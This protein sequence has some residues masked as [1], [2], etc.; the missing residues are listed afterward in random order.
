MVSKPILKNSIEGPSLAGWGL[1]VLMLV[2]HWPGSLCSQVDPIPVGQFPALIDESSGI[3]CDGDMECYTFNDSD[4]GGRIFRVSTSGAFL[5]Q[6]IMDGAQHIDYEDIAFA[7]DG[8]LFIGDFGNNENDRSDL[9]I[10]VVEDISASTSLSP[11]A[12]GFSLEDQYQFPPAP[13][14]R[15]FDIEAMIH[16]GD[17]LYLFTRNRTMPFNGVTKIYSLSDQAG[18]QTAFLRGQFYGNLDSDRAAITAAD[19][20]E[21]ESRIVLL[22]SGSI[23]ILTEFEL[24]F[25]DPTL[26]YNEF[27]FTADMEGLAFINNCEV[28]ISAE[29][30]MSSLYVLDI[31]EITDLDEPSS[32][33]MGIQIS[34]EHLILNSQGAIEFV[35]ILDSSGRLVYY[36]EKKTPI[37]LQG[38]GQGLFVVNLV[39]KG[40]RSSQKILLK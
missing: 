22:S 7:S 16:L 30:S 3:E 36:S 35:Q 6:V 10:Y 18:T 11:T 8:R 13:A 4:D 23:F 14:E 24:G 29:G 15:N 37:P 12:I 1:F 5:G 20:S 32:A 33:S 38:L 17:S 27:S 34:A 9:V 21:D 28:L 19:I 25:A 39:S 2:S 40:H 31:C 26:S